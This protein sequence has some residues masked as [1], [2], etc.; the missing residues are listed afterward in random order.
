MMAKK[1][2]RF[3]QTDG[4]AH[5]NDEKKKKERERDR[6]IYMYICLYVDDRYRTIY[7]INTC[8]RETKRE[9]CLEN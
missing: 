9:H 7:S 3:K 1:T 8:I 2:K 4:E 5:L 6:G